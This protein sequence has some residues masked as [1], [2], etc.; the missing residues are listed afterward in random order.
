MT[1]W[2]AEPKVSSGRYCC[3][4]AAYGPTARMVPS[5]CTTAPSSITSAA[6]RLR[7]LQ[8]T[9]LPRISDRAIGYSL[10]SGPYSY[11]LAGRGPQQDLEGPSNIGYIMERFLRNGFGHGL[12]PIAPKDAV[13]A[14][15][16]ALL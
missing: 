16:C 10:H 3:A 6:V 5:R 8:I 12:C 9:Y 2:S 4:S 11:L 13:E 14:P 7:I 1:T 15:G